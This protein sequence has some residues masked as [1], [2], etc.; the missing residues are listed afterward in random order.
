MAL[1][2]QQ[3]PWDAAVVGLGA[4]QEELALDH[5]LGF[6]PRA[7]WAASVLARRPLGDD[8]LEPELRGGLKEPGAVTIEMVAELVR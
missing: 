4:D 5:V 1:R 8:T 3:C 6:E 7:G 2:C